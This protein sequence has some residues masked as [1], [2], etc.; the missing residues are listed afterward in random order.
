M[1]V[2]LSDAQWYSDSLARHAHIVLSQA[3]AALRATGVQLS[4]ELPLLQRLQDG[5][6]CE[7]RPAALRRTLRYAAGCYCALCVKLCA[8]VNCTWQLY[9]LPA[10]LSLPRQAS[11]GFHYGLWCLA[12]R[13]WSALW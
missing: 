2:C 1:V 7:V 6:F 10:T 5:S 9:Q 4:A 12:W 3:G 8:Y 13:L 11:V